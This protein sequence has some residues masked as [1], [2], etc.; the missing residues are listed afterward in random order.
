MK[1]LFRLVVVALLFGGWTLAAS[2][3]HV[4]A[5]PGELILIPKDR[6][7]FKETYVDVRKWMP[8]DVS[9]HPMLV[10]RLTETDHSLALNHIPKPAAD[11]N[12]AVDAAAD[13]A[14]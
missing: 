9:A 8:A 14:L 12:A 5:A 4:V 1:K 13:D 6:L 3:L 11:A 10:K 7:N 2:A